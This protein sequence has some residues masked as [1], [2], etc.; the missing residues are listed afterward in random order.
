MDLFPSSGG[1]EI[2][3]RLR[4]LERANLNHTINLIILSAVHH[5]Q[6]SLGSTIFNCFQNKEQLFL[7]MTLIVTQSDFCLEDNELSTS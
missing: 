6:N 4:P 2:S 1:G 3:T 7:L 5:R